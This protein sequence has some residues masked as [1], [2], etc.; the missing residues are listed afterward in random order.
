M[1]RKPSS[2]QL[3]HVGPQGVVAGSSL[4]GPYYG[5]GLL[6][7]CCL[8]SS[9]LGAIFM[10]TMSNSYILRVHN[11]M[12]GSVWLTIPA[13]LLLLVQLALSSP[14]NHNYVACPLPGLLANVFACSLPFFCF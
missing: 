10:W 12:Q 4:A 6:R 14:G 13:A 8:V 5:V 11:A 3:A 7:V 9:L 1:R 2:T